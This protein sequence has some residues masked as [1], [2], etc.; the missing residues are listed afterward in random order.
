MI[1]RDLG[2]FICCG[3]SL[4]PPQQRQIMFNKQ[5]SSHS[6]CI[7]SLLKPALWHKNTQATP[8][9]PLRDS[10][11]SCLCTNVCPHSE[12]SDTQFSPPSCLTFSLKCVQSSN[13]HV[14]WRNGCRHASAAP[15]RIWLQFVC[16]SAWKRAL[17]TQ[18]FHRRRINGKEQFDTPC[19][20]ESRV[21][22]SLWRR[23]VGE[24]QVCY[25]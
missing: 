21:W 17:V 19:E 1:T 14:F 8:K 18:F 9:R 23:K 5:R 20:K 24:Y 16:T 2:S 13:R 22:K 3:I 25:T 10:E 7:C 15:V 12:K 6:G 11:S 4:L